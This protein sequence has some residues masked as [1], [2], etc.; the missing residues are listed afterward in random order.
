MERG[1]DVNNNNPSSDETLRKELGSL[2]ARE[3]EVVALT[4]NSDRG[5]AALR[6]A[7]Q[8]G[9]DHPISYATKL[10]DNPDWHPSGETRRQATNIAVETKCSHCGGHRFVAVLDDWRV[11]YGETYAPCK[12]CNA[13]ANTEFWTAHGERRVAVPQ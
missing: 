13:S 7:V 5:L 12:Q 2:G 11:P 3:F 9:A 8:R 6:Y 4:M 1:G 10:F